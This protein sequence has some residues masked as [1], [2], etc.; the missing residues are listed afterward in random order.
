MQGKNPKLPDRPAAITFDDG[1]A[2]FYAN[3]LPI[4]LKMKYPATLFIATAY[5]GSTSL[6]L[7]KEGV[8]H[9][10]MLTWGQIREIASSGVEI[11]SHGQSHQ[12]L[13]I[14]PLHQAREEIVLSRTHIEDH[15]EKP[16]VFFA[17]PYGYH[18]SA[19]QEI[20]RRAGYQAAFAVKHAIS[21]LADDLYALAR[22]IITADISNDQFIQLLNGNGIRTAPYE[23]QVQ[24][25]AWRT[26]RRASYA[27]K[28]RMNVD[29]W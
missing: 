2:D 10:A 11:G 8:S 7:K 26:V 18:S 19:V 28:R 25:K 15:L 3:A 16:V 4:L 29:R 6:W 13:D 9:Y 21:S 5:V 17:Y 20:L 14:L 1:L 22:I 23:E 12:Q 27:M 24:T